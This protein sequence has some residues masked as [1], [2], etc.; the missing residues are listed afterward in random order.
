MIVE[1]EENKDLSCRH[2]SSLGKLAREFSHL[3]E[4]SFQIARS[5]FF[6]FKSTFIQDSTREAF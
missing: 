2:D 1:S 3:L 5:C 4:V 6:F